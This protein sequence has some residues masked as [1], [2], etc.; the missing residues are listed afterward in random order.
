MTD[1]AKRGKEL[2]ASTVRFH[3]LGEGFKG[4]VELPDRVA[5]MVIQSAADPRLAALLDLL[6]EHDREQNNDE[7]AN[8]RRV[9]AE[10]MENAPV[11]S[12]VPHHLHR[13]GG[14]PHV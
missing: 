2:G 12:N 7:R 11:L 8:I 6:C 4:I 3:F 9:V 1:Q 14:T 13:T 10:L 5:L